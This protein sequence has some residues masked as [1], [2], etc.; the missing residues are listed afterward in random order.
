MK[1]L[2]AADLHGLSQ[3]YRRML[4]HAAGLDLLIIGGDLLPTLMPQPEQLKNGTYDFDAALQQQMDFIDDRL[5]PTLNDFAARHP[6]TRLCFIPGNHDWQ[7]AVDHLCA[8]VPRLTNIHG[9]IITVGD[10]ALV[11]YACVLD[12]SFWVKDQVRRDLPEDVPARGR[13][14][15]VSSAAGLTP[16]T[17]GGYLRER[18]SMT[19]EL[20]G[21]TPAD[22]AH[23]IA[24]FHSPPF[25]SGLDT[26]HD[27]RAIGSRAVRNWL[28]RH[29]VG[30]S[31][32]GH[33]HEGPEMSGRWQTRLG[34]TLAVNPGHSDRD[35][36]AV[37]FD[38]DDIAGTLRH[39]IHGA[40]EPVAADSLPSRARR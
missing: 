31:L 37:T 16:S 38:T 22:P 23:T 34:R 1:A 28:E 32:H 21:L 3:L 33:V 25:D 11:G 2:F 8:L 20:A 9:R 40:A 7:T 18:P 27:G 6:Q 35:L 10:I 26:M 14:A 24:V 19:E 39:T 4:E 17:D 5:A 15:L 29:Q 30:L 12:S 36:H 13:Y